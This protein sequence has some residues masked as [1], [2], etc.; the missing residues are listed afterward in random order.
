MYA[1]CCQ[2]SLGL[3]E[4]NLPIDYRLTSIVIKPVARKDSGLEVGIKIEARG[5]FSILEEI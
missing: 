3:E 2:K 5:T 4:L 1:E